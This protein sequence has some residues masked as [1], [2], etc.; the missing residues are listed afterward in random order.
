MDPRRA[1]QPLEPE[2]GGHLHQPVA[3][4]GAPRGPTTTWLGLL[5][6][7]HIALS[8]TILC[9]Y[10]IAAGA[11]RAVLSGARGRLVLQRITGLTLVGLGVRVAVQR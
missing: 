7:T 2:G 6:A 3:V 8:S 4:A 9:V 11:F 1:D 10:A 5:A